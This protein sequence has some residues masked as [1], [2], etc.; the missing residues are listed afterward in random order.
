M[1]IA[2]QYAEKLKQKNPYP[3]SDRVNNV[4]SAALVVLPR[5]GY[6]DRKVRVLVQ[7]L[8]NAAVVTTFL[9]R[10]AS[11]SSSTCIVFVFIITEV[12]RSRDEL[13][14]FIVVV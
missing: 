1:N 14:R 13:R 6:E 5:I 9:T 7:D 12:L 11:A 8:L 2:A 4:A 10:N 3:S